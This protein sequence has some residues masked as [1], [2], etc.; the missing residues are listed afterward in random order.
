[1]NRHPER[2]RT[3]AEPCPRCGGTLKAT[4]GAYGAEN[5]NPLKWA[6]VKQY[7]PDGCALTVA[8]FPHGA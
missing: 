3:L 4:E 1:M 8:D 2:N 7:C 5:A 6:T